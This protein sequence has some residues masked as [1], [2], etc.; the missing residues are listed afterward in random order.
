VLSADGALG[1]PSWIAEFSPL[2]PGVV[3]NVPI[4][5]QA[6]N[7]MPI[8]AAPPRARKTEY[9]DMNSERTPM[10]CNSPGMS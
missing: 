7:P 6:I 1:E 9:V 4:D 3:G 8:I 2:D 10:P 5:P